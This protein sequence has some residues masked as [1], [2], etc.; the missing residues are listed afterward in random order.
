MICTRCDRPFRAYGALL[1]VRDEDEAALLVDAW[2]TKH[3]LVEGQ[4][5]CF[6]CL[7]FDGSLLAP[8]YAEDPPASIEDNEQLDLD[9]EEEGYG[10]S[11]ITS[12]EIWECWESQRHTYV[13]PGS[14]GSRTS[15]G[16]FT[17]GKEVRTWR[18]G[19]THYQTGG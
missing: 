8:C 3:R 18:T 2:G 15:S 11:S 4:L 10:D 19:Y 9:D 1:V 14:R 7:R 17:T 13:L 16:R 12:R 5:V 6:A